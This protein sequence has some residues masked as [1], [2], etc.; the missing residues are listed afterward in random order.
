MNSR[1]TLRASLAMMI[2][3][4]SETE[5]LCKNCWK[6]N[7]ANR[8]SSEFVFYVSALQFPTTGWVCNRK[9]CFCPWGSHRLFSPLI[10]DHKANEVRY[11]TFKPQWIKVAWRSDPVTK[12]SLRHLSGSFLELSNAFQHC[13]PFYVFSICHSAVWSL[14]FS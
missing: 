14:A 7:Y 9:A 10:I 12:I 11:C 8:G 2:R 4:I 5:G 6:G 13:I 1:W 3:S